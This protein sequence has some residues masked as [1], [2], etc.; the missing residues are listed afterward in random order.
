MEG[1]VIL[2]IISAIL[3]AVSTIILSGKG[4]NLIAGYKTA[5]EKERQQYNIKRLRL[6]IALMCLLPMLLC[7]TPYITDNIIVILLCC[8]FLCILIFLFG[9]IAINTWYKKK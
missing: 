3:I 6:V 9:M 5:S 7:W 2:I 4:D 1:I 8:P